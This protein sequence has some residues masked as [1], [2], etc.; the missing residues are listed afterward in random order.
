MIV[1]DLWMDCKVSVNFNDGNYLVF[2]LFYG[3]CEF[4]FD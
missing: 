1:L 3:C 2:V 4:F